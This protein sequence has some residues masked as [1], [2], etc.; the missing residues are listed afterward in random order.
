MAKKVYVENHS[1]IDKSFEF[2]INN[3]LSMQ[4]DYDDVN[5]AEVDAA[6][7]V[8]KS[9]VEKHWDD[10][11]FKQEYKKELIAVWNKNEYDLQSDYDSKEDYLTQNGVTV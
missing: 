5:H 10:E 9:I 11:L 3:A 2:R 8:L 4:I 6:T 7:R 1:G